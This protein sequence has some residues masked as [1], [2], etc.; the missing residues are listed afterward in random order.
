MTCT[1]MCRWTGYDFHR[2]CPKQGK[3]FLE[4]WER[5]RCKDVYFGAPPF[6][7][8]FILCNSMP[9]KRKGR[10]KSSSSDAF[11]PEEKKSKEANRST[12]T[13]EAEDEVL[14][15]PSMADDLGK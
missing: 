11:S 9:P 8:L 3:Q 1:G 7:V 2:L 15:A 13:S 6:G 12:N 4:F 5:S 10:P 14:T